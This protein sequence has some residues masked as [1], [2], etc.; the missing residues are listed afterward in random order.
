MGIA[1]AATD[2]ILTSVGG[3]LTEDQ[4]R[5]LIL[6]KL[7]DLARAEL[8]RYLNAERKIVTVQ[9]FL[10]EN[11]RSCG[12]WGFVAWRDGRTEVPWLPAAG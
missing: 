12:R 3:Q 6:K 8:E 10:G 9:R 2:A 1:I 7:S 11:S 4:A 5:A